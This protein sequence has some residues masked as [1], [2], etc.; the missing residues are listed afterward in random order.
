MDIRSGIAMISELRTCFRR[1]WIA[2]ALLAPG[3]SAAAAV[4]GRVTL[5]DTHEHAKGHLDASGV[6]VWLRTLNGDPDPLPPH[7]VKMLQKS[8]KFAPHILAIDVGTTVDFPNV[9]P[10]F[11]SAFSNFDGQFFDL[12]LYPPGSTRSV[13][14]KRPGIVRVF[15]NIHPTMSAAI[16]VLDSRYFGVTDKDGQFTLRAVPAGD[17]ELRVFHERST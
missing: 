10:I 2:T 17:Y 14:F 6:V 3:F 1:F 7:H 8:K 11:H 9:D 16:V 15:C 5:I 4:R 13:Q 12:G